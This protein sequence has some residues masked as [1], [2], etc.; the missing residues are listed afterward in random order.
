MYDRCYWRIFVVNNG[1]QS[2]TTE[3]QRQLNNNGYIIVKINVLS[4]RN[5]N[6]GEK[7]QY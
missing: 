7:R 4:Q 5:V 2:S 6:I 1:V 3:R